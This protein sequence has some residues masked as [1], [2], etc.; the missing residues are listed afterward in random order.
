MM[1]ILLTISILFFG[2]SALALNMDDPSLAMPENQ[3]QTEAKTGAEPDCNICD[4]IKKL[5]STP[6]NYS[7][8]E[9][10]TVEIGADGN[11]IQPAEATK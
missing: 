5:A 8:D 4:E 1:R 9:I 6:S 7:S 10:P 11:N 3:A 2:L